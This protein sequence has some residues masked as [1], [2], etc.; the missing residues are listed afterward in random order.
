MEVQ[1]VSRYSVPGYPTEPD[2]RVFPSLLRSVPSRWQANPTVLMSLA[3][4]SILVASAKSAASDGADKNAGTLVAPLFVHGSGMGSFGC[5]V[6]NP[7]AF[8]SEDEARQVIIAEAKKADRSQIGNAWVGT[9]DWLRP[10]EFDP[11]LADGKDKSNNLSF[12]FVSL[13]DCRNLCG[14]TVEM[15][16]AQ[17]LARNFNLNIQQEKGVGSVAVFYEPFSRSDDEDVDWDVHRSKA[18]ELDKNELRKQVRDFV[19]WL[20]SQG[21]I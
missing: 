10:F 7:P 12:V 19:K 20:K 4:I 17:A 6:V 15:F 2:A 16:D 13:K 3:S 1:S 5:R 14:G 11:L 9:T 8:L 21:V 18:K